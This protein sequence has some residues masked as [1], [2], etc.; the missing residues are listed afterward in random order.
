ML[1]G[2][3]RSKLRAL[4]LV[5]IGSNEDKAF[6]GAKMIVEAAIEALGA[7]GLEVRAASQLFETPCFP[8]GNGPDFVNAVVAVATCLSPDEILQVLHEIE[9]GFRRERRQRWAPRSLDLDLLAVG[10]AVLPD[11]ETQGQWMDLPMERQIREAPEQLVL[12]HPR[13]QDRGFVLIP[14]AQIAPNWQHPILGKTVNQMLEALPE[15]EKAD[16]RPIAPG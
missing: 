10:C 11:P 16:I 8:A 2:E 13:L 3:S 9:A 7:A 12:P 4:P 6:G 14:M 15:A 5:A 1:Q